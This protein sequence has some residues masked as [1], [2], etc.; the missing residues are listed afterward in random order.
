VFLN[1]TLIFYKTV[2]SASA[3]FTTAVT[4]DYDFKD[5]IEV[6]FQKF[7]QEEEQGGMAPLTVF[8]AQSVC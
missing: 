4:E 1:K 6:K 7:L 2:W 8:T 3:A 5:W